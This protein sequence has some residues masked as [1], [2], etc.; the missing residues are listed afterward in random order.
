[1][2]VMNKQGS[3]YAKKMKKI[4][5]SSEERMRKNKK[6]NSFAP[7]SRILLVSRKNRTNN[8]KCGFESSGNE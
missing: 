3:E 5:F 4:V 8:E 2:A 6:N 7:K 1:M